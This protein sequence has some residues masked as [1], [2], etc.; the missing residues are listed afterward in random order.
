MKYIALQIPGANG[1]AQN[2]VGPKN[3]PTGGGPLAL[4]SIIGTALELAV[5]VAVISCLFMFIWG[6]FD[7]L[8][9]EGDKQKVAKARQ[10]LAMAVI[11]L[12]VIFMSFFIINTIY[13]FF[14]G[15]AVDFLGSVG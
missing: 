5:M 12:I 8:V 10:R 4:A 13:A 11:G 2:F 1:A 9:S 14:F 3:I 7:Y 15:S 6:G